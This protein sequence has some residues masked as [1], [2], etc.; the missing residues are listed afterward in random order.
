MKKKNQ[1]EKLLQDLSKDI[2]KHM[3][4]KTNVYIIKK[5]WGYIDDYLLFW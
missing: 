2:A 5:L 1:Q 4:V 3:I